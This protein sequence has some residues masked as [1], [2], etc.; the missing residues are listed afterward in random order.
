MKVRDLIRRSLTKLGVLSEGETPSA[1][2]LQDAL[3]DLNNLLASWSLENL[4][5]YAFTTETFTLVPG[6]QGQTMGPGGDFDTVRPTKIV[7][8]SVLEPGGLE[9]PLIARN[10][11]QWN[12]ILL[13]TTQSPIPTDFYAEGTNPL[14][15][16]NFWP[17]PPEAR[18]AVVVS[19]KPFTAF[20]NANEEIVFPPGWE[21][22]LVHNLAT[23]LS[24]DYGRPISP[25][26]GVN[27]TQAKAAIKRANN[28]VYLMTV[29]QALRTNRHFNILTGE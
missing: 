6:K 10:Y 17:I 9:T 7:S 13:K 28:R 20:V 21:R 2:Q 12:N 15:T 24:T 19:E 5:I 4:L 26:L 11:S 14:E 27:A 22:A 18:Q 1:A 3:S 8:V 23:E 29:D 25:E 16:I